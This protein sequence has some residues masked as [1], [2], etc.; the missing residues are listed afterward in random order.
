MILKHNSYRS[1]PRT[2]LLV[3]AASLLAAGLSSCSQADE[4]DFEPITPPPLEI[5][6]VD[7]P[8]VPQ[9]GTDAPS[10]APESYNPIPA[11]P[12]TGNSTSSP[13]GAFGVTPASPDPISSPNSTIPF[14]TGE[15]VIPL[16]SSNIQVTPQA[17][18]LQP[19]PGVPAPA[20]P[21]PSVPSAVPVAPAV[22]SAVPAVP[23]AAPAVPNVTGNPGMYVAPPA[24]TF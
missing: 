4:P 2:V 12:A 8:P 16:P 23:N 7:P 14:S 21:V 15:P 1:R 11:A 20:A 5:P 6:P 10:P 17:P 3:L 9:S 13:Y 19:A 24:S 22:P 18:V